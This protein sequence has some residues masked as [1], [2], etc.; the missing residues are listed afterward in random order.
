[1]N[2]AVTGAAGFIG[3]HLV[4][5]LIADRHR[6]LAVDG[7]TDFYDERLKRSNARAFDVVEADIVSEPLDDLLGDV[8]CVFHLAGQPGV[9]SFGPIFA[10]YLSR[11]V[12]ATQRLFEWASVSG[13]KVV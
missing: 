3:S 10:E 4:E 2:V 7:F 5:R 12:L 13:A 9:R 11:N 6:V 8:D 1:M